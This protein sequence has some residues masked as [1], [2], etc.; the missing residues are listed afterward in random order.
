M[1]A[2]LLEYETIDAEQI[3][4]IMAGRPV[5]PPKPA[6]PPPPTSGGDRPSA[7][8]ATTHPAQEA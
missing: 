3:E 8:A 4:D 1:T 6:A 5:R 7:P 2:A